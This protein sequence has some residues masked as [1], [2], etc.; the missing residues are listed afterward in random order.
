MKRGLALGVDPA[1]LSHS[2][3]TFPR[4]KADDSVP[5]AYSKVFVLQTRFEREPE[6]LF[7]YQAG[8]VISYLQSLT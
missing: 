2:Y 3:L 6:L 1:R 7:Y 5:P 8:P 4:R